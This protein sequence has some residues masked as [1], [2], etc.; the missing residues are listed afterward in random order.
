MTF[1]DRYL[2]RIEMLTGILPEA[3]LEEICLRVTIEEAVKKLLATTIDL[4]G[5]DNRSEEQSAWE[6]LALSVEQHL[7]TIKFQFPRPSLSR[8]RLTPIQAARK[9]IGIKDTA[10][11]RWREELAEYFVREGASCLRSEQVLAWVELINL[12]E[13]KSR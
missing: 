2:S 13:A 7:P 3:K 8:E 10:S 6:D 5:W 9:L 12:V 4:P 11:P 1:K